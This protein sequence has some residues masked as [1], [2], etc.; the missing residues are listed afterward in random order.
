MTKNK[1]LKKPDVVLEN[2]QTGF[3]W[4]QAHSQALAIAAAVGIL[5]GGGWSA[6][7][8]FAEKTESKAQESFYAAERTYLKIKEGFDRA[9]QEAQRLAEAKKDPKKKSD[10]DMKPVETAA[11][12]DLQKDYGSVLPTLKQ[13]IADH[14]GTKGAQMSALTLSQIYSQ[15][16][17]DTEAIQ[18]LK[19]LVSKVS[20]KGLLGALILNQYAS[21]LANQEKCNEAV[22]VWNQIS[23]TKGG[24]LISEAHLRAGVCYDQMKDYKKAQDSLEKAKVGD[25]Q[26]AKTAERYLRVV[27]QKLNQEPNS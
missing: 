10:A 8:Y 4:S 21:L 25:T 9:E 7:S 1:E 27:R 12:G 16:H 19:D 6:W 2:L 17:Q 11:S 13:V 26:I 24:F 14:S 15:Y 3:Q 23:D 18:V 5:L 22:H 20:S